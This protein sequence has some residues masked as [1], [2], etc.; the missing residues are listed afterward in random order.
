MQSS[1]TFLPQSARSEASFCTTWWTVPNFVS[2]C[3][4]MAWGWLVSISVTC[5]L[6]QLLLACFFCTRISPPPPPSV[7][8]G[9]GAACFS[10][11]QAEVLLSGPKGRL[12]RLHAARCPSYFHFGAFCRGMSGTFTKNG[13]NWD[14]QKVKR[15]A[16]GK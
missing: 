9:P 13:P 1:G 14:N 7:F 4:N 15:S 11:T 16:L 3:L 8:C 5:Q 10:P 12:D 6:G 2:V